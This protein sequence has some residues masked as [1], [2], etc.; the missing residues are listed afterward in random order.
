MRLIRVEDFQTNAQRLVI[1][2]ND[3]ESEAQEDAQLFY[4][5]RRA[6]SITRRVYNL[7]LRTRNRDITISTRSKYIPD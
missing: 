5:I 6:G 1:R 7:R 2:S 3:D 4:R